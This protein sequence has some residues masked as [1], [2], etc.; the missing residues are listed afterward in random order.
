MK[1]IYKYPLEQRNINEVEMPEGAEIL[2]VQVQNEI[3]V[4]WAI[5]DTENP[6]E[7]RKIRII[8]T[9][10]EINACEMMIFIDTFQLPKLGLVFHVFEI[11]NYNKKL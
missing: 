4:L 7:K 8:G 6:N 5:V 11:P 3:P 9:G 10:H 2:S 1:T